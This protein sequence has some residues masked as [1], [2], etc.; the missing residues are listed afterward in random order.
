MRELNLF[1][2][3]RR[4]DKENTYKNIFHYDRIKKMV[5]LHFEING[6]LMGY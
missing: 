3:R 6:V 2:R 4:G 1:H 5:Q